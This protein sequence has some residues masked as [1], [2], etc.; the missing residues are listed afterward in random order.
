MMIA[1]Q[2]FRSGENTVTIHPK[3]TLF[4]NVF[5]KVKDFPDSS[6]KESL[7]TFVRK[8]LEQ[9]EECDADALIDKLVDL[10]AEFKITSKGFKTTQELIEKCKGVKN[11]V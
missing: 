3:E 7:L 11:N 1:S 5:A 8:T 6:A 4:A 9:E 2:T 10:S